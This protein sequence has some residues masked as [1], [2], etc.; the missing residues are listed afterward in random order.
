MFP[1]LMTHWLTG[2]ERDRVASRLVTT[3]SLT[4]NKLT[5]LSS[6]QFTH[7]GNEY[8]FFF[9]FSLPSPGGKNGSQAELGLNSI[10]RTSGFTFL[11]LP[12]GYKMGR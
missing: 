4:L 12:F 11:N 3:C 2:L 8:H 10:P 5:A 1:V 9:P 6:P 7:P